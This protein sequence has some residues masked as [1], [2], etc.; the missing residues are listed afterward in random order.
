MVKMF[1]KLNSL[2]KPTHAKA[3]MISI[4][5]KTK[6][7]DMMYLSSDRIKLES[8]IHKLY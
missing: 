3:K 2:E 5:K 8:T 6:I 7:Y 4:L 1:L